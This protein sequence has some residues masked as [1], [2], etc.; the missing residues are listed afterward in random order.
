MR[1]GR[2][3]LH[4]EDDV[5]TAAAAGSPRPPRISASRNPACVGVL[6]V[7]VDGVLAEHEPR[8]DLAVRE[9]LRDQAQDLDLAG[10]EEL[11]PPCTTR[12]RRRTRFRGCSAKGTVPYVSSRAPRMVRHTSV[13]LLSY[14]KSRTLNGNGGGSRLPHS[15]F[16]CDPRARAR[17]GLAVDLVAGCAAL[18]LA[19][20]VEAAA[21]VR[22]VRVLAATEVHP[23]DAP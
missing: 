14:V 18:L 15:S 19:V 22:A 8:R 7:A 16:M 5:T 1:A 6:K 21:H 2:A 9:S 13:R 10:S 12:T 4:R 20:L 3:L 23:R 11:W 17:L